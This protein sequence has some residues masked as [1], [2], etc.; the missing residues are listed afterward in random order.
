MGNRQMEVFLNIRNPFS[1]Y[2][3]YNYKGIQGGVT[4]RAYTEI[5]E[6][7]IEDGF[8]AVITEDDGMGEGYTEYAA[9][10]PYQIKSA[11]SNNGN[12]N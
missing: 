7:L 11:N 9:F 10:N 1:G 6:K 8:D 12:F 5:R 3:Y 4:D 2:S